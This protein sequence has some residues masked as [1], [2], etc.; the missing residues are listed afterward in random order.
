L[1]Q[2]GPILLVSCAE[3]DIFLQLQSASE[4]RIGLE[5]LVGSGS[6]VT[7]K[8]VEIVVLVQLEPATEHGTGFA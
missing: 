2:P 8:R 5:E 3:I 6:I 7:D 1:V 4:C